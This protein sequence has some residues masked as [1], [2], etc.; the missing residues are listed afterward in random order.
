MGELSLRVADLSECDLLW[1]LIYVDPVWKKYDAPYFSHE[2][3]AMESFRQ[4]TFARFIAGDS[5]LGT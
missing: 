3:E 1:R 4:G 2:P 5:A